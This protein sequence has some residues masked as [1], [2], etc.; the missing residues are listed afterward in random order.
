MALGRER[1]MVIKSG[2]SYRAV[3]RYLVTAVGRP[4]TFK[5]IVAKPRLESLGHDP[6]PPPPSP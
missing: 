1:N 2:R 5:T 3:L 6:P 4:T